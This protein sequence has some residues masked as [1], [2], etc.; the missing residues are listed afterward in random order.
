[1]KPPHRLWI[2]QVEASAGIREEF[3]LDKALGYLIGEKFLN[4]L[5]YAEKDEEFRDEIEPFVKAIKEEFE[6]WEL[7]KYFDIVKR[8]GTEGHCFTDEEYKEVMETGLYDD[9][10][11]PSSH[12]EAM[13]RLGQAKELLL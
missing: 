7:Q 8:V 10:E 9:G 13:L 1:M 4:H 2:E 12:G 11:T 3:G 6:P 5:E